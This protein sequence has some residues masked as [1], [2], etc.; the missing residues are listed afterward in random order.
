MLAAAKEVAKE[1]LRLSLLSKGE[2]GYLRVR[3]GHV[4]TWDPIFYL[5]VLGVPHRRRVK[6]GSLGH[7][8]EAVVG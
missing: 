7:S 5:V 3:F 1:A 4:T 2:E 8:H 6:A